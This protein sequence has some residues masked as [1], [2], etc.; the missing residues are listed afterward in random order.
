MQ[1]DQG[2]EG[3]I[4]LA[5]G[6]GPQDSNLHSL[7]ARRFLHVLNIALHTRTARIHEYGDDLGLRYQLR[8]QLKPLRH[9][10]EYHVAE[11][12]DV[13][14]PGRARLATKPS[15][16]GSPTAIKKIGIVEVALFAAN[17]ASPPT[18]AIKSTLRPTRSVANPGSRSY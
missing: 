4:D 6:A 13:L 2:C 15:P 3:C 1:F 14:P 16:T 8:Q 5:F 9:Q 11:A 18:A 12:C 7:R 17:P 10:L